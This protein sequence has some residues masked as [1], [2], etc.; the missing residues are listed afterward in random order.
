MQIE[1][2]HRKHSFSVFH[3][4]QRSR[5]VI[6]FPVLML[7]TIVMCIRFHWKSGKGIRDPHHHPHE[8][9]Q[10]ECISS[11]GYISLRLIVA[12]TLLELNLNSQKSLPFSVVPLQCHFTPENMIKLAF[13]IKFPTMQ[14]VP[15]V[16]YHTFAPLL[17]F[18]APRVKT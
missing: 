18:L 12:I 3:P 5:I 15:K 4:S 13:K 17:C 2:F 9:M 1:S 16:K 8:I 7:H 14:N 10:F 6:H 11:A